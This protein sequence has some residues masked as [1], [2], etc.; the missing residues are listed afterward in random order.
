M[1]TPSTTL[2]VTVGQAPQEI[3]LNVGVPSAGVVLSARFD[4]NSS[5]ATELFVGITNES[6]NIAV[7]G[8]HVV[9]SASWTETVTTDRIEGTAG[10]RPF[11]SEVDNTADELVIGLNTAGTHYILRTSARE[12]DTNLPVLFLQFVVIL[13]SLPITE[14]DG[15][16]FVFDDNI[17]VTTGRVAILANQVSKPDLGMYVITHDENTTWDIDAVVTARNSTGGTVTLGG[18]SSPTDGLQ[19]IRI[20]D[21]GTSTVALANAINFTGDGVTVMDGGSNEATVTISGGGFTGGD[22]NGVLEIFGA[23]PDG[24]T[25]S[26]NPEIDM[27]SAGAN[28]SIIAGRITDDMGVESEGQI[29]LNSDTRVGSGTQSHRLEVFGRIEFYGIQDTETN[30]DRVLA[31]LLI[32]GG[33]VQLTED[34]T[35]TGT[36]SKYDDTNGVFSAAPDANANPPV[37]VTSYYF[38][39]S[40]GGWYTRATGGTAIVTYPS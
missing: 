25:F 5:G 20:E 8:G 24:V 36:R 9:L 21:E 17:D 34:T 40:D 6:D 33:F 18:A 27:S 31:G 26:T 3:T 30:T 14:T 19:G 13:A 32:A 28:L 35:H 22:L 7:N 29:R 37:L 1:I 10:H 16:I 12:Y 23:A 2:D 38:D 39:D 4:R 11:G 15:R